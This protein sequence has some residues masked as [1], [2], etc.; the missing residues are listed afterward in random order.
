ME[1]A[2]NVCG[3]EDAISSEFDAD[4][5]HPVIDLMPDQVDIEDK[6]GTMRLGLY[7]CKLVDGTRSRELY[8]EELV[9][10]RHRH[11]YEFNNAYRKQLTDAGLILAGTSPDERLVEIIEVKD[12]PFFVAVQFH[13]EFKSR[14]NNPHPLFYGFIQAMEEEAK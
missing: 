10:E 8:G 9:Y 4:A 3:I 14:P 13:P 7:P 12:H 11:R 5:E 1:F 2:R 6:G